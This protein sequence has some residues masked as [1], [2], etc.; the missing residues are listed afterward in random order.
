MTAKTPS[1]AD[2]RPGLVAWCHLCWAHD[3]PHL[4]PPQIGDALRRR[5]TCHQCGTITRAGIYTSP[6]T[7]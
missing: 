4:K 7:R 1:F 6:A 5:E 3:H 2:I